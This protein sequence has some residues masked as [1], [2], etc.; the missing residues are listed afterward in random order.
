MDGV[1]A[2]VALAVFIGVWWWL[3]KQLR[4]SGRGF[5]LRHLLGCTAAWMAGLLIVGS[6]ISMGLIEA[7]PEQVAQK[8]EPSKLAIKYSIVKD[9]QRG[10]APRKVE[11]MLPRRLTD[12]E[13][14]EVA[15]AIRDE[16]KVKAER[17]FIGFRVE[18]QTDKSYWANASFDPDYKG[19]LIGL[20]AA[21]YQALTEMDL[22]A[23]ADQVGSWL[24]DGALGHVMV[25]YK[26]DG[27]YFI[28]SVF[29]GGGKNTNAYIAKS[30]PEGGLRLEEPDN[31]FGEYYI[32]KKDG[33]LEGWGNNG[34]YMS[35]PP[36]R[37]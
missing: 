2:I 34:K 15:K 3:V 18:G 10:N 28:D 5:L 37:T 35:L 26:K 11:A 29:S 9:E 22:S 30:L 33:V 19:S 25:L 24:R 27:K 36:F 6:A 8:A 13:L 1:V 17:T 12:A 20:G 32:L 31:G 23:Y 21:D 7:K 14:A 16:S 4:K